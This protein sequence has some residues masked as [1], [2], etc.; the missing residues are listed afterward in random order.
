MH[1]DLEYI[2]GL[3]H[4]FF[5][6]SSTKQALAIID[7]FNITGWEIWFQVEFARFIS[8][9]PSDV[10]WWREFTLQAELPSESGRDRIR[11]DFLIRKKGWALESYAIL[12]AKVKNGFSE[13]IKEMVGDLRKASGIRTNELI[14]RSHWAIGIHSVG[15]KT[16]TD[17]QQGLAGY[18]DRAGL[19]VDSGNQVVKVLPGGKF[20]YSLFGFA[21]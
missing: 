3:I 7:E 1:K 2:S 14:L 9:H 12:E 17:L 8:Q 6:Q 10:E 21:A 11:P 13:C 4:G 5:K 18:L 20:A 19:P 15:E 16:Q